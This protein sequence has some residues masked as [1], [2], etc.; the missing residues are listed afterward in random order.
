MSWCEF[1]GYCEVSKY[2]KNKTLDFY[3]EG[4]LNSLRKNEED[5]LEACNEKHV[6]C[7]LRD[8]VF[9]IRRREVLL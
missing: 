3:E 2:F 5:Y 4:N 1:T 6:G 8:E 7:P 9:G